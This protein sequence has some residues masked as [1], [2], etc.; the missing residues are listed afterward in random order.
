MSELRSRGDLGPVLLICTLAA[1]AYAAYSLLRHLHY[2]SGLD[3]GIF[4]QAVWH[5]SN[6]ESPASTVK[7]G[8]DLRADHF[9]PIIM[10]LAPLYWIAD[11]PAL[12][13][14]AQAVLVAASIVPVFLFARERLERFPA[15]AMA[16]AYAL[17]WGIWA[18]VGFDFHEVAF[19]PLL[20]ALGILWGDRRQWLRFTAAMVLLILVKEDMTLVA[21]FFGVWLLSRRDWGPGAAT[22]AGG[23]AA[24][25]LVT[26]VAMPHYGDGVGFQYWTYDRLGH[27]VPDAV[28]QMVTHPW[29][30]FE[31]ALD[32]GQKVKTMGGMLAP[33]LAL[34]L[35]SRVGLLAIPLVAERMLSS[36]PQLWAAADTHYT[37]PLAPILVM[38]AVAGLANVARLVPAEHR[39]RAVAAAAVSMLILGVAF[40]A[41]AAKTPSRVDRYA[42]QRP[43]AEP[44]GRALGRVPPEASVATPEVLYSR[45]SARDTADVIRPGMARVDYIVAGPSERGRP[46]GFEPVFHDRGWVVFRRR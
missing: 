6:F 18:G 24:C 42:S 14:V 19:A 34:S 45:V 7:G 38:A 37:L 3:T 1:S 22:L 5:Y 40:N 32:D 39:R 25:F 12:L 36:N 20:V 41:L 30:P 27:D 31:V 28:A 10:V 44:A 13:L 23:V 29:L 15:Y 8:L 9:H 2:W 35:C 17:F 26:E 11:E 43:L 4:N 16:S 46:P 33:F 21:A